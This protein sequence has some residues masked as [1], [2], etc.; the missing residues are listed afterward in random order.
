M[1]RITSRFRTPSA[2]TRTGVS[3]TLE[4]WSVSVLDSAWIAAGLL[5]PPVFVRLLRVEE[6]LVRV[7]SRESVRLSPV[8]V[9]IV[10]LEPLV[11]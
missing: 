10:R 5:F 11:S 1:V 7:E 4:L 2:N 8:D 3:N 6:E 9:S